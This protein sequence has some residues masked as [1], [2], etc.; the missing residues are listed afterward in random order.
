MT[1]PEMKQELAALEVLPVAERTP[2]LLQRAFELDAR[3]KS[4]ERRTPGSAECLSDRSLI[5]LWLPLAQREAFRA[6]CKREGLSLSAKLRA[7]IAREI[8]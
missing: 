1:L 5:Q 6:I 7:M 3:I 8:E 4:A 2:E